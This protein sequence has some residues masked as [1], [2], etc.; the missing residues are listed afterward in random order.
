MVDTRDW[1]M[2]GAAARPTS[3]EGGNHPGIEPGAPAWA[4]APRRR[5]PLTLVMD[6]TAVL[7]VG[8]AVGVT[9]GFAFGEHGGT[10]A[11]A[12]VLPPAPKAS[13]VLGGRPQPAASQIAMD[14]V[15]PAVARSAA[16]GRPVRIGVFG[17]SF[18]VGL[19]QGLY[20]QF[21][22]DK[23]YE[24]EGF[25]R[26]ATGFTRYAKLNLLDDI[27]SKIDA[28]PVDVAVISFGANDTFDI[29]A[30]GVAAKYMTPEWQ[31]I[32]GDRAEAIVRLLKDRGI[33][34]YWV[35][36]PKMREPDFEAKVAQMNAFYATRMQALGVP[37]I[38]TVP[39][40]VDG[41]GQYTAHLTDPKTG[42][43]ELARA[44]DG[45]HMATGHA[46]SLLTK[47]LTTRIR[48]SVEIARAE[49]GRPAPGAEPVEE[50]TN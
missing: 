45:I 36:L 15:S 24:V 23:G 47:G 21:K 33:A 49:A 12:A 16:A 19:T 14:R 46:Y 6:R 26:Q 10:P 28:E 8:I 20:L 2:D 13:P 35:G 17:D 1:A 38:D 50:R 44:N 18:G 7:F 25:A 5:S 43:S 4:R 22:G 31:K 37:F 48:K 3:N 34:V 30:D 29:Y 32:V 39:L 42:R 40:S 9:I 11:P 27:R 41:D